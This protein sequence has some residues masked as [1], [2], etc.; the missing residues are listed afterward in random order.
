MRDRIASGVALLGLALA[1]G[2]GTAAWHWQRGAPL[3]AVTAA[4]AALYERLTASRAGW[5]EGCA[6]AALTPALTGNVRPWGTFG[7]WA[8]AGAEGVQCT[9]D[10]WLAVTCTLPPGTTMV[11]TRGS[12]TA[13]LINTAGSPRTVLV[14]P[15]SIGCALPD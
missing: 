2:I 6:Q 10:T 12:A 13:G 14:T 1:V 11:L 8:I 5:A 7:A 9:Q 3:R 4:D 15:E